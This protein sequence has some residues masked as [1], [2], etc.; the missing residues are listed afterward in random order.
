MSGWL[1]LAGG[2]VGLSPIAGL[3]VR[4]YSTHHVTAQIAVHGRGV[5][6]HRTPDGDWWAVRLRRHR[7]RVCGP[8][9]RDEPPDQPDIGVRE[10]RRPS[11]PTLSPGVGLD[12]P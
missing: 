9:P 5:Y 4:R 11:G 7:A 1:L 2:L 6:F 10:P 3:R 12:L 8:D